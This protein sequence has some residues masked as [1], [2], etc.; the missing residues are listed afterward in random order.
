MSDRKRDAMFAKLAQQHARANPEPAVATA[1]SP[2]AEA[3]PSPAPPEATA[4]PRAGRK[5]PQ[6]PVRGKRAH[7]DYCQ[8]NAYIPR[9]LRRAVEKAL[10]DTDGLDYSTLVAELLRKWLKSQGVSE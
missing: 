5:K 3:L 8:A 7:P 6:E 10:L 9:S 2:A 1:E 4:N